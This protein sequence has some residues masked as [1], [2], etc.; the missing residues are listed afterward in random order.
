MLTPEGRTKRKLKQYLENNDWF[1]YWPVPSGYGQQM[2]DCIA[3]R[4][5]SGIAV[6]I[7][8]ECKREGV[9]KPAPRQAAI[10][11]AMRA[12]GFRTYVVTIENNELSWHEQS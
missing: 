5:S 9:I 7:A 11:K 4:V 12:G 2:V 8:I 3:C 10:M 6:P 1:Q